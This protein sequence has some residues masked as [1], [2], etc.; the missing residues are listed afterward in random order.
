MEPFT[1]KDDRCIRAIMPVHILGNIC[2]MDRFLNIVGQYPIAIVED[3]TEAFGSST[4]A[5]MPAI[6][7]PL[8]FQLQRNK[9]ISTGGGGVIVTDDEALAKHAKHLTTTAKG[10]PG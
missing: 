7:V 1:I 6:S 5:G 3:A 2:D 8:G 10:Q 9:I 4:R